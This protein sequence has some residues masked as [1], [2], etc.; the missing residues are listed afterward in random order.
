MKFIKLHDPAGDVVYVRQDMVMEVS[1]PP[2]GEFSPK[3]RTLLTLCGGI[4][5]VTELPSDVIQKLG[6]AK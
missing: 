4:Q 2:P 1:Q 5:A 3:A 6:A